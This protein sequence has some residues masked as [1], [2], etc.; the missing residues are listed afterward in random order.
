MEV[1]NRSILPSLVPD[2]FSYTY[3]YSSGLSVAAS[4]SCPVS[5]LSNMSSS[6]DTPLFKEL[7]G[8]S[9]QLCVLGRYIMFETML[10]IDLQSLLLIFAHPIANHILAWLIG[11]KGAVSTSSSYC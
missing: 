4:G 11:I 5:S 10:S 3:N 2:G 6:S 1:V 8:T 7:T 9:C